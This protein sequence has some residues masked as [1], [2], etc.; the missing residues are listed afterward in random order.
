[1]LGP[2][3]FELAGGLDVHSGRDTVVDDDGETLAAR[4]QA[5]TAPIELEA[6]GARIVAIAVGKHEYLVADVRV[7]APR[8]HHENVV[9]GHAGDGV[10]TLRLEAFRVLN[11]S[12]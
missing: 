11:E 2:R 12:G 10:D 7:L 5:E 3:N 8:V 1:M 9:H 6:Q 4:P